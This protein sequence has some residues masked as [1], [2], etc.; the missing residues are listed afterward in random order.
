MKTEFVT[1]E[2]GYDNLYKQDVYLTPDIPDYKITQGRKV[3]NKKIL[4]LGAGTARDIKYLLGD[5]DIWAVDN[6]GQAV[7]YLKSIGI[8][9]YKLDLDQPLKTIKTTFDIIIAKD[10]LEHLNNPVVLVSEMHRLISVS[11][12][13]VINVPNHF[14]LPMRMRML[15]G[16]NI[17]WKSLSHDHTKLF[18]EWNYMHKIFFTWNG[19]KKLLKTNH[20]KIYK[21]FFDFG[22]L[23]HYSQPEMVFPYLL[24][25]NNN[26]KNMPPIEALKFGWKIFNGIFPLKIRSYIVSLSP[27]LLCASFYVWVKPIRK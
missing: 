21:T 11:G 27:S 18:E 16:K 12:Y 23:N 20:L 13:A 25:N 24:A 9:A 10:I 2:K 1:Q 15:F 17:I 3:K 8:K 7:K 26:N 6:S 14:Y 4:V 19:F 5:N 22:T